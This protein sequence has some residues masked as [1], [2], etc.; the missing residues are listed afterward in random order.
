MRRRS[1]LRLGSLL[2]FVLI[3]FGMGFFLE[4]Y[5]LNTNNKTDEAPA[6]TPPLVTAERETES[7]GM[8]EEENLEIP[9]QSLEASM[10]YGFRSA[11]IESGGFV[12]MYERQNRINFGSGEAYTKIEGLSTFASDPFRASFVFGKQNISQ[13]TLTRIWEQKLGTLQTAGGDV[14]QG[15]GWTGMPLIIKWDEEVRKVLGVAEE[16]KNKEGFT[17]L[18]YPAADGKIYFNELETGRQTRE[19]VRTGVVMKGTALL[20]P[21]GYPVMYVGQGV[22]DEIDGRGAWLRAISLIENKV[23]WSFGGTD[24]DAYRNFQA[25]DGGGLIDARADTLFIPGENGILYSAVLNTSFDPNTGKLSISPETLVKYLYSADAYGEE[26]GM[27]K[28]GIES[29]VAALGDYAF[30]TDNG[31]FLQCIDL[32][33]MRLVY[34]ID[35]INE[36]DATVVVSEEEGRHYLYT[37]TLAGTNSCGYMRKH[38][39]ETG[40]VLW[41]NEVPVVDT[42][43]PGDTRGA[44]GTPHAGHGQIEDLVIFNCTMIPYI[45]VDGEETRG[46]CVLALDKVSGEEKWRYEQENGFWSSPVVIYDEEQKAYVIQCDRAGWMRMLDAEN[47]ELIYSLDMGSRI[48]STPAVFNDILVVGTRGQYGSGESA[49]IIAVKIG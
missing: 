36:S 33:G 24:R 18:I 15:T 20:D 13:K 3:L 43:D 35:L 21:R 23:I 31:G 34:A 7:S 40:E 28:W 37:A 42:G 1:I 14:W 16:F 26:D 22:E 25:Y 32:N 2:F 11:V 39:A 46:A 49:K 30:V 27:R 9:A 8:L 29:S 19:P 5:I 17:E 12:E 44:L 41:E 10:R 38:E 4:R 48:E 47:G 45:N 6:A